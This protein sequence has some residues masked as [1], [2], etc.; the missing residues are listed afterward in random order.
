MPRPLPFLLLLTACAGDLITDTVVGD[1]TDTSAP[2]CGRVRGTNGVLLYQDDGTTVR[3]PVD[4]PTEATRGTG[5]TGP[6]DASG[7]VW[8]AVV[9]GRVF[10]SQDAGCNWTGVGNLPGTADWALRGTMTADGTSPTTS[11]V[12]SPLTARA[13]SG[14]SSQPSVRALRQLRAEM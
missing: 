1:G 7:L 12:H 9:N 8:A 3:A 11:G 14:M 4:P 10:T 13:P 2:V 5:V 6:L